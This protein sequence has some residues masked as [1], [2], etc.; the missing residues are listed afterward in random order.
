LQLLHLADDK[1]C[2]VWQA[3]CPDALA[4]QKLGLGRATMTITPKRAKGRHA[5]RQLPVGARSS[6]DTSHSALKS[7]STALRAPVARPFFHRLNAFAAVQ[8]P[9]VWLYLPTPKILSAINQSCSETLPDLILNGGDSFPWKNRTVLRPARTVLPAKGNMHLFA[10]T[11][12]ALPGTPNVDK[13]TGAA[14]Q[15]SAVPGESYAR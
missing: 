1:N 14:I 5:R 7:A 11:L 3:S 12:V 2:L 8:K 15:R 10:R 4:T 6:L 9:S 13:K